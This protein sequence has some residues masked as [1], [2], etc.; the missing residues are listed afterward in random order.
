MIVIR[1]CSP[2][3]FF[4]FTFK[5]NSKVSPGKI[6]FFEYLYSVHIQSG[7]TKSTF[8]V[9]L[10]MYII[11]KSTETTVS[12]GTEPK[13]ITGLIIF[14]FVRLSFLDFLEFTLML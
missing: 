12:L 4:V 1:L 14:T 13:S 9:V 6:G 10:P 7:L 8:R 5:V 11:A 3:L 2:I